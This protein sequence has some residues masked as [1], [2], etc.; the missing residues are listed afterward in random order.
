V[1]PPASASAEPSLLPNSHG[2]AAQGAGIRERFA[3]GGWRALVG[4]SLAVSA[5]ER[6][7]RV[8]DI[9]R[10]E[11][12]EFLAVLDGTRVLGLCGRRQL[13][14]LLG[15]RYGFAVFARKPIREHLMPTAL[16][17]PVAAAVTE[18]FTLAFS[19]T[20]HDYYDDVI[21]VDGA[22]IYLGLLH[23]RTLV[24]LQHELLDQHIRDI[25]A[26]QREIHEKNRQIEEDLRMAHELQMA[27][28]PDRF[29]AFPPTAEPGA[30]ALR[31]SHRF[32]PSGTVGGDF[33]HVQALSD[34]K[35][36]IFL[37]DVMGHDVRAA[38]VTAVLRALV[39]ELQARAEDPAALLALI[40][41]ELRQ[42]LRQAGGLMFATAAAIVVD[43]AE[44]EV[45]FSLAGHPSPM[46]LCRGD[47]RC[48]LLLPPGARMGPALGIFE[49]AAYTTRSTRVAP[50]DVLVTFTDGLFEA[51]NE[52]G[53]EFGRDR[54]IEA[55][56]N[57]SNH[58][59]E[60]L[61]DGVLSE[62]LE[63]A[64]GNEFDDDVCV[65]GVEV[66]GIA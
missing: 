20:E 59:I 32:K 56:A 23:V 3:E 24:R 9:F 33:F 22:G 55:I 53:E 11:P 34:M 45:R 61:L 65:L 7:E 5:D 19:R 49:D 63:F 39:E 10:R 66:H 31:F 12:H 18:V 26:K 37:C 52:N 36:A 40:N 51:M 64:G 35:A 54:L 27:M 57:R 41:R 4:H 16:K 30:S 44:N 8:F 60:P 28:L 48:E 50:G 43:S 21:L 1:P 29:P 42:I 38:L 13:G 15:A 2:H 46:R 62:V 17:V 58:E 25:E 47:A 6:I 14:M